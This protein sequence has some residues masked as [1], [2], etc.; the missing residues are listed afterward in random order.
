ME[1]PDPEESDEE[2][3]EYGEGTTEVGGAGEAKLKVSR[4]ESKKSGDV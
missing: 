4:S 3:N 2:E 1:A